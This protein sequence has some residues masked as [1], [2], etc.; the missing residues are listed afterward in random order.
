MNTLCGYFSFREINGSHRLMACLVLAL[1]LFSIFFGEIVPAGGGFGWD[2]V[3][4][5]AITRNLG[6]MISDGQLSN[7]YAQRILPSAVV[8]VLLMVSDASFS[9]ANIIDGFKIYSL[10][11]LLC[12]TWVWKRISDH[13]SLSLKGRWI[14]F[15]GIFV[16]FLVSKEV[17]YYAVLTDVTALFVSLLLLLFYLE[18]R[19]I[20][21]FLTVLAGSFTWQVTGLYGAMLMVFMYMQLSPSDSEPKELIFEQPENMRLLKKWWITILFSSIALYLVIYFLP[22]FHSSKHLRRFGLFITG[23]PSTAAV[24]I[25]ILMMIGSVKLVRSVLSN[26]KIIQPRSLIFAAAGLL[27]PAVIV[28]LICNADLPNANG[29]LR[30]LYWTFCPLN[31][32]GKFLMPFLTITLAWGPALLLLLICWKDVCVE[33]RRL[34]IG[35][36]S[37]AGITLPLGLVTEP[38]YVLGAWPFL[39]LALVLALERLKTSKSFMYVFFA[40]SV[41]YAQFW[42]KINLAPWTGD[43]MAG[44]LEF[45]KQMFFMHYGPWMSWFS[46]LVQFPVVILSGFLLKSLLRPPLV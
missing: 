1:G 21:L 43:D 30:V 18:R 40:L 29:F 45:P 39:V 19:P 16:N 14:G 12:G 38:R 10:F 35:A 5:A 28:K 27:I 15:A 2:G 24:V 41:L 37:V 25:A 7:Y 23:L 17:W 32:D 34:G 3:T 31:G 26:W 20:P 33:L 22:A 46:Y 42:L 44:L 13:C 9:N 8:R 36:M 6:S 4:Y 11:L